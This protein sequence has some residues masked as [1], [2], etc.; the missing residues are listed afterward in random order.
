MVRRL[1]PLALLVALVAAGPSSAARSAC[2]TSNPPNMLKIAGGSSQTAQLEKAFQTN[3]QVALANSN[4]CPLTG[5]LAGIGIDFEAPSSGASGI[6][7]TSASNSVVVGT[8]ANGVAIA[9]TFVANDTDGSYTVHASSDYG[10]VDFSLTNTSRGVVA[11]IAAVGQTTQEATVNSLY[12]APLQAQVLDSGGRPVQG[13][14]VVFSLGTGISGAGASFLG[15]GGQTSAVTNSAGQATSPAFVANG[16]PGRFSATASTSAIATVATYSLDNHATTNTI[17]PAVATTQTTPVDAR[18]AQPLKAR[19][20]DAAGSPI[21]GAS[22]TFTIV[23]ATAG[24]GASF[25]GGGS[26]ASA[27][28]DV[29]GQATSPPLVANATAGIFSATAS[30]A[31]VSE[32]IVYALRNLAG[33]ATAIAAGGAAS[34]STTVGTRFPIRLAVTVTDAHGNHVPGVVVTFT[35]PARGASGH[36]G[37]GHARV[38]KATTDADG[39]AVAPAFAAYAQ[40]GGFVVT[41][42]VRGTSAAA[43]FALVNRSRS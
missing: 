15:G 14:T 28:T 13:V 4:G 18:Y 26:Q 25:V 36:F 22:V 9:P 21:E 7:T 41:A 35:A 27:L 43:A 5:N 12:G 40:A 1:A 38:A 39:V 31:G 3:L 29:N 17:A 32:P 33:A 37:A 23:S 34:E 6:F 24:A 42:T 20:L 19:V 8:D 2:P 16:S 11:S 30:A 10:G